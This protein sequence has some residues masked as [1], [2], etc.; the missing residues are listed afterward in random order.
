MGARRGLLEND[1]AKFG[2]PPR[3]VASWLAC[4][5]PAARG[6]GPRRPSRSHREAGGTLRRRRG[7]DLA[8]LHLERLGQLPHGPKGDRA[9][10]FDALVV[11][12]AEAKVH[13]VFL[14]ETAGLSERANAPA[15]SLAESWKIQGHWTA[16]LEAGGHPDHGSKCRKGLEGL[17]R[18]P[19]GVTIVR[20]VAR[21]C[22]VLSC[23]P[24]AF[25][26]GCG[27][28]SRAASPPGSS[29]DASAAP[30][31]CVSGA[32]IPCA[33][34]TGQQGAQTCTSAG[35]FAGCVCLAP[36]S[37]AAVALPDAQAAQ[38][39]AQFVRSAACGPTECGKRIDLIAATEIDCGPCA[40]GGGVPVVVPDAMP[41]TT[42]DATPDAL[43]GGPQVAPP[44]SCAS[45]P[46]LPNVTGSPVTALSWADTWM[47]P[48]DSG[49]AI[50]TL[51][52]SSPASYRYG[53]AMSANLRGTNPEQFLVWTG[54]PWVRDLGDPIYPVVGLVTR[55]GQ[56]YVTMLSSPIALGTF[57]AD[58]VLAYVR[59]D[60]YPDGP[61]AVD[62]ACAAVTIHLTGTSTQLD[63]RCNPLCPSQ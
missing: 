9:A 33:C 14:C 45:P 6:C 41:A 27:G 62:P 60:P 57:S 51:Q 47:G 61:Y 18:G 63:S 40:D 22:C 3:C 12:E 54:S 55:Q 49:T 19:N 56:L 16:T 50:V 4:V 15:E 48:D 31:T 5:P 17:R 2:P 38:P 8:G 44:T 24:V 13:H 35:T 59:N 58:L 43:P 37:G 23:L 32:S 25:L 34:V 36:D 52:I 21:L 26:G 1:L 46:I 42:P 30:A 29:A 7:Q 10:R 20:M 28:G 39:D 53:D 11:P